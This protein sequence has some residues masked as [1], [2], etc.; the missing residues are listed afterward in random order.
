[1]NQLNI[2]NYDK[3]STKEL[4]LFAILSVSKK[5]EKCSFP[6]LLEEC[7]ALF[8]KSFFLSGYSMWPDSRKLDR[9]LR[10]LRQKKLVL[11]DISLTK[12]GEKKALEVE[13]FLNQKR[14]K[15]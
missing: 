3:I 5:K 1:M 9:P 13:V 4:I 7:F 2:E 6:R 11:D 15:I 8:P 10:A 12:A 14:L